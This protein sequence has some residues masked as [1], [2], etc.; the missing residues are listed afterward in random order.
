MSVPF[1][2][3]LKR[4]LSRIHPLQGIV[5][6]NQ[7]KKK[8]VLYWRSALG[9]DRLAETKRRYTTTLGL[10]PAEYTGEGERV[11]DVGCGPLGGVFCVRTWPFMVAV[12]PLWPDYDRSFGTLVPPGVV[13]ITGPATELPNEGFDL[14]WAINSLDHSG[15]LEASIRHLS[16]C[17]RVGGRLLLHVH[18]RTK[19]QC[20][21]AHPVPVTERQLQ[22]CCS[23]EWNSILPDCP[24]EGKSYR[25]WLGVHVRKA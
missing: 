4:F 6:F 1:P 20:N 22:E 10:F 15:N 16:S 24:I 9:Q 13:R 21:K 7:N 5:G 17:L 18:M 2:L 25:T 19:E 12:D 8:E 14:V 3:R 23:W 11:A